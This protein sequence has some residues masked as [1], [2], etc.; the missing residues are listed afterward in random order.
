[1]KFRASERTIQAVNSRPQNINLGF[2]FN[3][4]LIYI[5]NMQQY[6]FYCNK[7]LLYIPLTHIFWFQN[8]PQTVFLMLLVKGLLAIKS[9][10]M[11]DKTYKSLKYTRNRDFQK[12]FAAGEKTVF[13][14]YLLFI[15]PYAPSSSRTLFSTAYILTTVTSTPSTRRFTQNRPPIDDSSPPLRCSCV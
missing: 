1:M 15:A 3:I 11:H 2:N 8:L 13:V 9:I 6:T 7:L 5:T 4:D 14:R 12:S 10:Y